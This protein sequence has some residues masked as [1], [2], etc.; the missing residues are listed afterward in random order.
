[1]EEKNRNHKKNNSEECDDRQ[2]EFHSGMFWLRCIIAMTLFAC[3]V[4]ADY[5]DLSYNRIT[6][7]TIKEQIADNSMFTTVKAFLAKYIQ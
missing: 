7:E 4:L 2:N 5:N 6:A 3:V 1:M